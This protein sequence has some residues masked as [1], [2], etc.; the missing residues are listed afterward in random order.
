MITL[1]TRKYE[2]SAK[3]FGCAFLVLWGISALASLAITV[4]IIYAAVHFIHK[5]W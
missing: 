1:D 4:G 2:K 3:R 5:Y